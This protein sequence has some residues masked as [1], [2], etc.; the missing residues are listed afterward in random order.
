[1]ALLLI[2]LLI[3]IL[4]SPCVDLTY[5]RVCIPIVIATLTL[6]SPRGRGWCLSLLVALIGAVDAKEERIPPVPEDSAVRGVGRLTKAPEWGGV[7]T[8]LVVEMH[9]IGV[10]TF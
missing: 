5:V 9:T 1:M 6:P 10:L 7:G 4:L 2:P 8:D 3:G